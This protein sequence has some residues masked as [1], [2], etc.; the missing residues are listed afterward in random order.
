MKTGYKMKQQKQPE[1]DY[2]AVGAFLEERVY[3]LGDIAPIYY[4]ELAAHFNMPPV[5][6]AWSS[7]PLCAILD[8]IDQEDARLGQPFRS[9][10]VIG[11]DSNMPGDGFF[12]TYVRF[13]PRIRL[14][15]TD[16]DKQKLFVSELNKVLSHYGPSTRLGTHATISSSRPA[17]VKRR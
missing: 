12:K 5:T 10:L 13:N 8:Q 15:R 1:T 2:E 7:H 11:R 9:V 14:P 6:E 16:N 3:R 17:S 4:G